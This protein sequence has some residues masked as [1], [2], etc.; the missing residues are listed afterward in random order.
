MQTLTALDLK[1][2]FYLVTFIYKVFGEVRRDASFAF[3]Y[4]E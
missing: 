1:T 3:F 2:D 4:L